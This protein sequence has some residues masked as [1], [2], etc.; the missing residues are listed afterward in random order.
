MVVLPYE[1]KL[2]APFHGKIVNI[3][4]NQHVVTLKSDEGIELL[5]HLGINSKKAANDFFKVK[6]AAGESIKPGDCIIEFDLPK[7]KEAGIDSRS[8]IILLEEEQ[9]QFIWKDEIHYLEP[10]IEIEEKKDGSI[11]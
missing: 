8:M 7:L 5:I 6:K 11:N 10:F 1:G 3:L 9:G 2:I 4:P